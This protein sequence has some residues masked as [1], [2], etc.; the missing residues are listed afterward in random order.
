MNVQQTLFLNPT[1][2]HEITSII[3]QLKCSSPGCDD[4]NPKI[5]KSTYNI[6]TD[7]L[8]HIINLALSL[9]VF[10]DSMKVAKVIP[11]FKAGQKTLIQN[12][13]PVSILPFF[14]KLFEK[15]IYYRLYNF[16]DVHN[17]LNN[18]QFGFRKQHST[19]DALVYLIDKILK[20]FDNCN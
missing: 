16:F 13:R 9:G 19:T 1:N 8:V 5:I 17:L 11:L 2:N 18:F 15:V 10:P 6:Y 4:I 20:S 12:Y 3:K 7:T 14:S